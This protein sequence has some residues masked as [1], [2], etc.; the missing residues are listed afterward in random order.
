M[1]KPYI[2]VLKSFQAVLES[3]DYNTQL[4]PESTENR[5]DILSVQIPEDENKAFSVNLLPLADSLDG[6][7]FM[8]IYHEFPFQVPVPCP[9]ELKNTIININR[10]LPVGHFNLTI[11]G[12]KVYYKYILV[13]PM[14]AD[15]NPDFMGDL[16]DMA[17]FSMT[18]FA[19]NFEAFKVTS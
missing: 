19:A 7:Y 16:M 14:A 2:E 4:Y 5:Y 10:Q 15:F 12:D 18:H 1:T 17:V 13:H 3:L 6:S 9:D 11:M 8:Q